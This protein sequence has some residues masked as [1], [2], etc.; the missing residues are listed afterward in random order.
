MDFKFQMWAWHQVE[1]QLRSNLSQCQNQAEPAH[2]FQHAL[3]YFVCSAREFLCSASAPVGWLFTAI[4]RNKAYK[5]DE[6]LFA[7][8]SLNVPHEWQE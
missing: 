3:L 2:M 6:E 1:L 8:L 4:G 5:Q 7:P